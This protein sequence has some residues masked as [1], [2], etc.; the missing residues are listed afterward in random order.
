M[1]TPATELFVDGVAVEAAGEPR[2]R[3]MLQRAAWAAK[4]FAGYDAA[5]VARIV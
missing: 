1:S 2:G 3:A 5:T 4:A